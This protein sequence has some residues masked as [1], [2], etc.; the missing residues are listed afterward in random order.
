VEVQ[1]M[2]GSLLY[3]LIAVGVLTLIIT[4]LIVVMVKKKRSADPHKKAKKPASKGEGTFED[5]K[6]H[7]KFFHGS[8]HSPPSFSISL[9]CFSRGTFKIS[10]ESKVDKF[11]K[12][13]GIAVEIATHDPSFDERFYINT[14]DKEFSSFIFRKS[15]SRKAVSHIFDKGFTQVQQSKK[16]LKASWTPY[17][18]KAAMNRQE[19]EEIVSQLYSISRD[20]LSAPMPSYEETA[21]GWKINRFFV[22]AIPIISGI[23][24]LVSIIVG[25]KNYTPLDRWSLISSTL[26]YSIPIFIFFIWLS[27]KLLKG[28][29]SSHLELIAVFFIALVTFPLFFAGS[30]VFLNG[31]LDTSEPTTHQVLAVNKYYTTSKNSKSY[32]V[33]VRSWRDKEGTETEKLGIPRSVYRRINPNSTTME[34]VTKEG[35]FNYQW[36]YSTRIKEW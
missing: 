6:Y 17:R 19:V 29:S 15:A 25:F 7:Y 10:K 20:V 35:K 9:E 1:D 28:R 3:I 12:R 5:V 30:K 24:G 33:V 18:A 4:I 34:I 32:Y 8:Q 16:E 21:S 2:N 27:A 14:D 36:I 13:L 23:L 31:Y 26:K 22:F 11:F